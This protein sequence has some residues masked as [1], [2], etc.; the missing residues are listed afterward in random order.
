WRGECVRVDVLL[1]ELVGGIV[2]ERGHIA[3][4]GGDIICECRSTAGC[5]A[6][7]HCGT[8]LGSGMADL[9]LAVEGREPPL[10]ADVK[11]VHIAGLEAVE[12]CPVRNQGRLVELD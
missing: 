11:G 8:E 9:A 3:G 2:G 7:D 10:F 6:P 4:D 5:V 1:N 12:G